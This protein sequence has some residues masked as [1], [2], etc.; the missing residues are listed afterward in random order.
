MASSNV[1]ERPAE[2]KVDT[3]GQW[4]KPR[5]HRHPMK[6]ERPRVVAAAVAAGLRGR[7]AGGGIPRV[8]G[9]GSTASS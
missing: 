9:A 8:P 5:F 7:I 2:L 4:P 1:T 6:W 3:G